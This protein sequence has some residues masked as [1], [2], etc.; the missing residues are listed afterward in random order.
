MLKI[1]VNKVA[2]FLLVLCLFSVAS[3]PISSLFAEEVSVEKMDAEGTDVVVNEDVALARNN[4]IRDSLRKVVEQAVGGIVASEDIAGHFDQI[5]ETIYSRSQQYIQNYRIIEES[6]DGNLYT[7][8][9][10]AVVSVGGIQKELEA[11]GLLKKGHG[12]PSIMILVGTGASGDQYQ[13]DRLNSMEPTLWEEAMKRVLTEKGLVVRD[14]SRLSTLDTTGEDVLSTARIGEIGRAAGV[15]IIIVVSAQV[16]QAAT[17]TGTEVKEL[18]ARVTARVVRVDGGVIIASDSGYAASFSADRE[19]GEDE[20]LT[21]AARQVSERLYP[22]IMAQWQRQEIV[23]AM[24]SLTVSGIP[25]YAEYV[26]LRQVLRNE[27]KGVKTIYQRR[28]ERGMAMLDLEVTVDTETLADRLAVKDFG[29]FVLDIVDV[30]DHHINVGYR[31]MIGDMNV[32]L[33]D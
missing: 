32:P 16:R 30:T 31:K 15:D 27:L 13:D 1:D 4:A 8:H 25:G 14:R 29:P 23:E 2:A 11:L 21:K 7:V 17:I 20:A 26:N 10:E 22:E 9:I 12:V 6:A 28:M 5:N 19:K 24:I 33:Q 3:A 18:Q